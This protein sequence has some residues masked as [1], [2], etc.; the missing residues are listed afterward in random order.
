M[1]RDI[2]LIIILLSFVLFNGFI[3]AE[4]TGESIS[5]NITGKATSQQVALSIFIQTAG[6]LPSIEIT[7]PKNNTYLKNESILLSYSIIN[8]DYVW[9]NL[10]SSVNIT[11]NSSVY[12]NLSQGPHTIYLYSN[13]TNGTAN[14]KIS[15][16][17]NSTKFII[18]FEEY[19]GVYKGASTNFLDYTY[20]EI[21]EL[22]KITLENTN[23]GKI[24]FNEP[25]NVTN[26]KVNTDNLIDLDS[27][28]EMSSNNIYLNST[29]ITNFNKSATIWLYNLDFTNPRILKD[30]VVCP[31]YICV[32]ES[33]SEEGTL[34][35]NV[36]HFTSY[37]AEETPSSPPSGGGSSGGSE[38]EEEIID[39]EE[40]TITT[41]PNEIK[42]SLE[43]GQTMIE[44]FY[45]TNNYNETIEVIIEAEGLAQFI[46]FNETQ[47]EISP[48]S[49]KEIELNFTA[50]ESASPDSYIGKIL[51][52]TPKGIYEAITIIDI[53]SKESSLFDVSINL[54]DKETPF[55]PGEYLFFKTSVYN[56]GDIKEVNTT[57]K[58][59]IK[60][61]NGKIIFEEE[62]INKIENYFE[63][64]GK[65]KLPKNLEPGRYVL[66]VKLDYEGKIAVTSTD[67][68]VQDKKLPLI[69]KILIP[70]LLILII[71]ILL[72]FI[73]KK[74][75]KKEKHKREKRQEKLKY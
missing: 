20:E 17:A 75:E 26:D 36:T 14:E 49:T 67:F 29:E 10:D 16:I 12:I 18:L 40:E 8:G 56:I 3:S 7:S 51:V 54:K 5:T 61:I 32:I 4:I 57:I 71:L 73:G 19:K 22:N 58:Y 15:F 9:Y 53:Q 35:F 50:I 43:Q 24:V 64:D 52:I 65:I 39:E 31:S 69:W 72:W 59:T 62:S 66:S 41:T 63:K 42:I 38:E 30:G 2:S 44:K 46:K 45:L 60:D 28:T 11:I 37:S 74:E 25:I 55:F 23:Y 6:G 13:N 48:G 70:V 68:Q 27:N 34:K 21:Q 47:F 33:Y 1:K